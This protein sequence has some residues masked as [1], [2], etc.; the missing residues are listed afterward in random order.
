[1]TRYFPL[2]TA[3]FAEIILMTRRFRETMGQD[4]KDVV[5]SH[6]LVVEEA[7]EVIEAI[8]NMM[9]SETVEN[10]E[11]MLKEMADFIYVSTGLVDQ[12]RTYPE[13]IEKL[14][15]VVSDADIN[16]ITIASLLVES[17]YDFIGD[18]LL[19]EVIDE[20]HYANLTKIGPVGPEYNEDGK[21]VKSVNYEP[22]YL[23]TF[24]EVVLDNLADLRA[25]E[26]A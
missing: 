2:H 19:F 12:L 14:R 18:N 21:V 3:A 17:T 23:T 25:E 1:M 7:H 13:L 4:F 9:G 6:K 26:A 10:A 5:L 11:A 24:A 15:G 16:V 8:G 22:P 20:V